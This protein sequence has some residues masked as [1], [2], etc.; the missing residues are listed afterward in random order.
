MQQ[1]VDHRKLKR[2]LMMAAAA[3]GAVSAVY[4]GPAVPDA[5]RAKM[6]APVQALLSSSK[7]QRLIIQLQEP[8]PAGTLAQLKKAGARITRRYEFLPMVA[9]DVPGKFIAAVAA[10]PGVTRVSLDAP[11]SV[12]TR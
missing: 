9:A 8:T 3:L 11:L 12:A 1:G 2:A 10:L 6:A 4:A 5:P 7:P